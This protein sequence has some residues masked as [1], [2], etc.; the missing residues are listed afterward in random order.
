MVRPATPVLILTVALSLL[1]PD[2]AFIVRPAAPAASFVAP[3]RQHAAP[4]Q[5]AAP[6]LAQSTRQRRRGT[7]RMLVDPK[8]SDSFG[9]LEAEAEG[10]A[11]RK[12]LRKLGPSAAK[13][14]ST[15]LIP[16]AAALGYLVTPGGRAVSAVGAAV[17]G[18]AGTVARRKMGDEAKATAPA[19]VAQLLT[20]KDMKSIR[21]AEVREVLTSYGLDAEAGDAVLVDIYRRFLLAMCKGSSARASEIKELSALREALGLTGEQLGDAHYAASTTLYKVC[22]APLICESYKHTISLHVAAA[23]HFFESTL[24][25]SN[26]LVWYRFP[27]QCVR[28]HAVRMQLVHVICTAT[29]RKH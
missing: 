11:I 7:A 6:A 26:A 19:A 24:C 22:A 15:G 27:A 1:T 13:A 10:N 18:L 5:Q 16:A 23:F 21:P 12:A 28:A 9:E 4:L 17:S 25:A 29:I 8:G 2:E 14:V 20:S 3:L